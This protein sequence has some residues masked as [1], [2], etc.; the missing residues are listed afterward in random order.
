[1]FEHKSLILKQ[2]NRLCNVD[3]PLRQLKSLSHYL[4]LS[5]YIHAYTWAIHWNLEWKRKCK[6]TFWGGW[7]SEM[8]LRC[9]QFPS[10]VWHP[11]SKLWA[12][13]FSVTSNLFIYSQHTKQ[14]AMPTFAM[15]DY[16]NQLTRQSR[17]D[18]N[19]W[20]S[21]LIHASN[22]YLQERLTRIMHCLGHHLDRA[23]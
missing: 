18:L 13:A 11:Q 15:T 4:S 14:N 23:R 6:N 19:G 8:D 17:W 2:I 9:A 12:G 7:E 22:L 16:K 3:G 5:I 20:T 10:L 1:M 21:F